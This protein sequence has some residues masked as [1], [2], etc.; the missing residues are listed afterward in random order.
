MF[1][2]RV[3]QTSTYIPERRKTV[4]KMSRYMNLTVVE[5][6][7]PDR[8]LARETPGPTASDET[9]EYVS[10]FKEMNDYFNNDV[11]TFESHSP[12]PNEICAALHSQNNKWYRVRVR[13]ILMTL[14]GAKADCLFLDT[15]E[16]QM[17]QTVKIQKIP[18]RFLTLPF[19]IKVFALYG[20]QPLSL[21]LDPTMRVSNRPCK[22]WDKS[23]ATYIK[24]M[25]SHASAIQAVI[26]SRGEGSVLFTMIYLRFFDNDEIVSLNDE[27]IN[28]GYAIKDPQL[29]KISDKETNAFLQDDLQT[30]DVNQKGLGYPINN[31]D[32]SSMSQ[33]GFHRKLGRNA[34]PVCVEVINK[35]DISHVVSSDDS[36]HM[37][38]SS[39]SSS[40]N[41]NN[42]SAF[43]LEQ[44]TC[45]D[46]KKH[47]KIQ[48]KNS[49]SGTTFET[50]T[51]QQTTSHLSS[52]NQLLS[53]HKKI[54]QNKKIEKDSNSLKSHSVCYQMPDLEEENTL[55]AES[56][57]CL[58][59]LSVSS[60]ESESS[61]TTENSE[62]PL[63]GS[64]ED[65]E[66]KNISLVISNNKKVLCK[67]SSLVQ[68]QQI[69]PYAVSKLKTGSVLK[70]FLSYH[71]GLSSSNQ[72]SKP[73]AFT[74]QD[75]SPKTHAKKV[76]V[77]SDADD[78]NSQP[79]NCLPVCNFKV[80]NDH[81]KKSV[82]NDK[83][84]SKTRMRHCKQPQPVVSQ[85][86]YVQQPSPVTNCIL[87]NDTHYYGTKSDVPFR[88]I[89]PEADS[90]PSSMLDF[91]RTRVEKSPKVTVSVCTSAKH[92]DNQRKFSSYSSEH[93]SST[94]NS[95]N[96]HFFITKSF[97][98]K[99]ETA[100]CNLDTYAR[101]DNLNNPSRNYC[102][103][104][105]NISSESQTSKSHQSNASS[106][107]MALASAGL[108]TSA[109]N[110]LNHSVSSKL[111]SFSPGNTV[112]MLQSLNT[113][114]LDKLNNS[115]SDNSSETGFSNEGQAFNND[116][117]SDLSEAEN[118]KP[119]LGF[120]SRSHPG[121][122][123]VEN[124]KNEFK[125]SENQERKAVISDNV[126]TLPLIPM[127]EFSDSKY[128]RA[129][130]DVSPVSLFS[131]EETLSSCFKSQMKPLRPCAAPKK[132]TSKQEDLLSLPKMENLAEITTATLDLKPGY[133]AI[134]FME[135]NKSD[136]DAFFHESKK[137][138]DDSSFELLTT[139]E[140]HG[141]SPQYSSTNAD[142][143]YK[144]SIVASVTD[145]CQNHASDFEIDQENKTKE[146]LP[147]IASNNPKKNPSVKIT[148][149]DRN[150]HILATKSS[151]SNEQ[152][153]VLSSDEFDKN[154]H[155]EVL[156]YI[157]TTIENKSF[158]S[159]DIASES[160]LET[161]SSS[162]APSSAADSKEA[163]LTTA[164]MKSN[165]ILD[166]ALLN[167][168]APCLP[169]P[170]KTNDHTEM[171]R[172]NDNMG[173]MSFPT[174]SAVNIPMPDLI[175]ESTDSNSELMSSVKEFE[176]DSA[177]LIM[178]DSSDATLKTKFM[179]RW[180]NIKEDSSSTSQPSITR[181]D[182]ITEPEAS[183][184]KV[185]SNEEK[186]TVSLSPQTKTND[187]HTLSS[188]SSS[189]SLNNEDFESVTSGDDVAFDNNPDSILPPPPSLPDT[190]KGPENLPSGSD[191]SKVV[192]P[193]LDDS[194]LPSETVHDKLDN[195]ESPE[196]C[197]FD[198]CKNDHCSDK[199]QIVS[200]RKTQSVSASTSDN[201]QTTSASN[202][203]QPISPPGEINLKITPVSS[204]SSQVSSDQVIKAKKYQ[205]C[206]R[207]KSLNVRD[208][209]VECIRGRSILETLGVNKINTV[210]EDNY[211]QSISTE[212]ILLNDS[213]LFVAEK[214][215]NPIY[216]LQDFKVPEVLSKL[217]ENL[218]IQPK[219]IQ[220]Y[221]WGPAIRGKNM[222]GISPSGSGKTWAYTVPIVA[223][224]C[225]YTIY[226]D[227]KFSNGPFALI[228]VPSWRKAISVYEQCKCIS[229]S[230]REIIVEL[231][232]GGGEENKKTVTLLNGCHILVATL[233]CFLRM[234]ESKFTNLDRLC[235]LIIDDADILLQDFYKEIVDLMCK[236]KSLVESRDKNYQRHQVMAY[237][238]K[239]TSYI[240]GFVKNAVHD[241]AIVITDMME[242]AVYGCVK[243]IPI[244]CEESSRKDQLVK[245]VPQIIKQGEKV[246]IFTPDNECYELQNL[247]NELLQNPVAVACDTMYKFEREII[248][249]D[250]KLPLSEK[251][252]YRILVCSDMA[253]SDL[254]INDA[255]CV[256]NYQ[257]PKK[258]I[259][260]GLRIQT[261][262]NYYQHY[263]S[264]KAPVKSVKSYILITAQ[265][266]KQVKSMRSFLMR[267][268]DVTD[269]ETWDF[270]S[271]IRQIEDLDPKKKLCLNLKAFGKCRNKH[272][273]NDRHC[274]VPSVDLN[275]ASLQHIRLPFQGDVR[276]KIL[277][278]KTANNFY[279]RI[280]E[281]Q[282]GTTK[283]IQI[284]SDLASLIM[285]LAVYY[286]NHSNR[287][288]LDN[289]TTGMLCIVNTSGQFSRVKVLQPYNNASKNTA[290]LFFVD[291]GKVE[292][293]PI[294]NLYQLADEFKAIPFQA[295]EVFLCRL[296]PVDFDT[297]WTPAANSFAESWLE[298]K[299]LYG[300]IRFVMD[301]TLWLDPILER[302]F[303]KAIKTVTNGPSLRRELINNNLAI[304]NPQHLIQLHK[305]FDGYVPK[306]I[307]SNT[308][309]SSCSTW[310]FNLEHE[311][312][313]AGDD[314]ENVAISYIFNPEHFYVQ[315]LD[316]KICLNDLMMK[317]QEKMGLQ[318]EPQR[319]R[320]WITGMHCLSKSSL[321]SRWYRVI[322]LSLL[323]S[324]AV[325]HF[326]DYGNME[327]VCIDELQTMPRE[328]TYLPS[329]AIE[330]KLA[331][332]KPSDDQW[333]A[334]C[335]NI[336]YYMSQ[337]ADNIY[338][339]LAI[340]V[341]SEIRTEEK[342]PQYCVN[343][344]DTS[345]ERVI[346]IGQ[347]LIWWKM[348]A[349]NDD[350]FQLLFPEPV[351][352]Q[353][354]Y[355]T[356]DKIAEMCAIF[357]HD[358]ASSQQYLLMLSYL[359]DCLDY[360]EKLIKENVPDSILKCLSYTHNPDQFSLIVDAVKVLVSTPSLLDNLMSCGILQCLGQILKM[361][362]DVSILHATIQLIQFMTENN[363]SL[364][365]PIASLK[366]GLFSILCEIV[367]G[368][369]QNEIR[370]CVCHLLESFCLADEKCTEN[371]IQF[372]VCP[373]CLPNVLEIQDHD[374]TEAYLSLLV[375]VS[376]LDNGL[377]AIK[378]EKPIEEI[379]KIVAAATCEKCVY[380]C[381]V[382]LKRLADKSRKNKTLLLE[383]NAIAIF[384]S[385]QNLL[386]NTEVATLCQD[387]LDGL[388]VRVNHNQDNKITV[389]TLQ[390]PTNENNFQVFW[391]QNRFRLLLTVKLNNSEWSGCKFHKTSVHFSFILN[392]GV[393]QTV[394]YE[395]FDEVVVEKCAVCI[396]N[397]EI[398][399]S[400][401]KAE[402]EY[403][404][405][406]LQDKYKP[407]NLYV[408]FDK[409]VDSDDSGSEEVEADEENLFTLQVVVKKPLIKLKKWSSCNE[410]EEAEKKDPL[411]V[412]SAKSD[413]DSLENSD[414]EEYDRFNIFNTKYT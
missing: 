399:L 253:L 327:E 149:S 118:G 366:S 134:G 48:C 96:E 47:Q 75:H 229:E 119:C 76:Q 43:P 303:M 301:N 158:S 30:K 298:S 86:S 18:E 266:K 8:I 328:L 97:C 321:D 392:D 116:E 103:S 289:L 356:A 62:T 273:C 108:S 221:S 141:I 208:H 29:T 58:L 215:P 365:K 189:S 106:Q 218:R 151:S 200:N 164:D 342:L 107:E 93:F 110:I 32:C 23:A 180:A 363:T 404:P 104:K 25:I 41:P 73:V 216:N 182:D 74:A 175:D 174:I 20:L 295:V 191:I 201:I 263:N 173:S 413:E 311:T 290:Q 170:F 226:S 339:T 370:T 112:L 336:M 318:T 157:E 364:L 105:K 2:W 212:S 71:K 338:K 80:E 326:V 379:M 155:L 61:H 248:S 293:H 343:L 237:S 213:V 143:D 378:R 268:T 277:H 136:T 194:V 294:C 214:I 406:L 210:T 31:F 350:H 98:Q 324:R 249:T 124:F 359:K 374:F 53:Y 99:D 345:Y 267:S 117:N 398:I 228:L 274:V 287:K 275:G 109:V 3:S 207:G 84:D 244:M 340:N 279:V 147:L 233:P 126:E 195:S 165:N 39:S 217:I 64:E 250:W 288:T 40:S 91:H 368:V 44:T 389:R 341:V 236:Y 206:F 115:E 362:D 234:W 353:I 285:G 376:L 101:S 9:M 315:K 13:E 137:E 183:S 256:V 122:D 16:K 202:I 203:Q 37:S 63:C 307:P 245:L 42:S 38:S 4:L 144:D 70:E 312:L 33:N 230:N 83:Q 102:R 314:Y 54:Q 196:Q 354:F 411:P 60:F 385:C 414:F 162:S 361:N 260:V 49:S 272:Q 87:N 269:K 77:K 150:R 316:M 357:Y 235:H 222:I 283:S 320:E 313:Q 265:D 114:P 181:T 329:Q 142:L 330:C 383:L 220:A 209:A 111:H 262:S 146:I 130:S 133:P 310:E 166:L 94:S 57:S 395:L 10:F 113:L 186:H 51:N 187:D 154:K 68:N 308:L 344:L 21:V 396:Q 405:R 100:N 246:I 219:P 322:I 296:H 334:Q 360:P 394:D 397:N 280:L 239:W 160:D 284:H 135:T 337:T 278:V 358:D 193:E 82:N 69:L 120:T 335:N 65:T 384:S 125:K 128:F 161:S 139:N 348:A 251:E 169:A 188:S 258:K 176:I 27:L 225:Q 36:S 373:I 367:K 152:V 15:G 347:E 22:K 224:L 156:K 410:D 412:D 177:S 240:K 407:T 333:S 400:F 292:S 377:V 390:H 55:Q 302:T 242:A 319:K 351:T 204:L 168:E 90:R 331:H 88:G 56:Q 352:E 129:M 401:C 199:A 211:K 317:I 306:L 227:I 238:S 184:V 259:H 299:M 375:P 388:L 261:M 371:L 254:S 241:P 332:I 14:S 59:D 24:K 309:P 190:C 11:L 7:G 172:L 26:K 138:K 264:D 72:D 391:C 243:Q 140:N 1:L 252:S 52:L 323:E 304:D 387:L 66:R 81:Q 95:D 28:K 148:S 408:D 386:K 167:K 380:K 192:V 276:V 257:M 381:L 179:S 35:S 372:Q 282:I 232:Y 300:K 5:V 382:A 297:E 46:S 349:P 153:G 145:Y 127:Q 50:S 325:V 131:H 403:W 369:Y 132:N 281:H 17:V 198:Q 286:S 79:K 223:S 178:S 45:T 171:E 355:P 205:T 159:V 19:Q 67:N 247:L 346:N 255:T 291:I 271:N 197:S 305:L 163:A 92:K 393:K 123:S 6:Q 121:K 409:I 12:K 34:H 78:K 270:L 402:F 185:A 85:S 89:Q 231:V